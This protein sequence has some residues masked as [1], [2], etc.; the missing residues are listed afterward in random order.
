MSHVAARDSLDPEALTPSSSLLE[1]RNSRD[2]SIYREWCEETHGAVTLGDETF[3]PADILDKLAPD[4]A[5]RAR[6]DAL[7]RAYEDIEQVACERFPSIVAVPF[8]RFLEGPRAGITRLHRLRDTWESLVRLLAA[9]ALAEASTLA[10]GVFLR[11]RE[12]AAQALRECKRRD[13]YSDKLA[14]RIGLIEAVLR[15]ANEARVSLNIAQVVPIDVLDEIRRM[16]SIRNGFS[17][18]ATK[19]DKQALQL[20]EEAYPTV[21]DLFLDLRDLQEVSLFRVK[22]MNP[23]GP[24][25]EIERLFGHSQNQRIADL[26]LDTETS[27]I[28]LGAGKVGG[29]DRVLA[30][31]G[32]R[33]IDLSPFIYAAD[34]D[35]GHRT[36]LLEFK[37]RRDEKWHL[38]CVS[39]SSMHAYDVSE[40]EQLLSKFSRL[41]NAET[42]RDRNE[43]D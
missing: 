37:S 4:A 1:R 22:S 7:D 33:V 36:R 6:I 41:L 42:A 32:T 34:D 20:I 29:L 21:R 24:I 14:I 13:L 16:N 40:H 28:V 30:R 8:Q 2:N 18:E 12:S 17:H 27:A 15:W 23:T 5:R 26:P 9:L 19:S 10:A 31:V 43:R 35:S 11:I 38:E 25:A 3:H 39:D